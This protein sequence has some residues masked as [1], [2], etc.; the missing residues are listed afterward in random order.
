V[1]AVRNKKKGY[2]IKII[3]IE[4]RKVVKYIDMSDNDDYKKVSVAEQCAIGILYAI[5]FLKSNV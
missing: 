2:Y 1:L 3:N 4:E 5:E